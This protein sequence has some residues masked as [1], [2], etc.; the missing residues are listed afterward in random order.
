MLRNNLN[1]Q[2]IWKEWSISLKRWGVQHTV[3]NLL[4]SAG[5]FNVFFAQVIYLSQPFLSGMLP[6][7]HLQNL[8][9]L[10]EDIDESK[11]FAAYLR[12][13]EGS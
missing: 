11:A 12:E 4:E 8:A 6:S 1:N 9:Y 7:R 2:D 10:L 13:G 3:A 5:A